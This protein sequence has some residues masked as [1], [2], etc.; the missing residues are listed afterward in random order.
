MSKSQPKCL[1]TGKRCFKSIDHAKGFINDMQLY[2]MGTYH[3]VYCNQYH[4]SKQ[5]NRDKC[6][7][8]GK[9]CFDSYEAAWYFIGNTPSCKA[10]TAYRCN[11]CDKYHLAINEPS[12]P[13]KFAEKCETYQPLK[14]CNYGLKF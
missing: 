2:M 6:S 11:K 10:H 3:C 5:P 1:V 14:V 12:I 13:R 8:T 4:L 9:A 7:M